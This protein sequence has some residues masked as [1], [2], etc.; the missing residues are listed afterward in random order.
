MVNQ[1]V[2]NVV[3]VGGGTAG[4]LAAAALSKFVGPNITITLVESDEI[5]VVGVGEATIPTIR[6]FHYLLG[7]DEKEFLSAVNGTFKLG[8][9]FSYWKNE[10]DSYIH[11]FGETGRGSWAAEFH[12]Y[13]RKGLILDA[14][15]AYGDYCLELQAAKAGKFA[16]TENPHMN[17]AYHMD[18]R[19]YAQ[20]LRSYSEKLGVKRIEGRIN[21]VQTCAVSGYI[22]SVQLQSGA[23]ISGDLFIDCSG[24]V[25]LLIEQT[26]KTGYEDWTHW[27]PCNRAVAVQTESVQ[28]ALP[29]TRAI[30]HDSG[31]QW[32]IPLQNRVG[33]GLVYSSEYLSDE[34]AQKQLLASVNGKTLMEPKLIKFVTGCRVKNWNKNCVAL[35]LSSG[36]VEPLE[37]TSIHLVTSALLRLVKLFPAQGITPVCVDEF[38]MQSRKEMEAVRDF[39]MLHYYV[40]NRSSDFWQRCR[41]MPVPDSLRHRVELF[42]RTGRIFIAADELFTLGSW[43]QVMI[44]QGLMP[45]EYHPMVDAVEEPEL[46]AFLRGYKS[47]VEKNVSMLPKHADFVRQFCGV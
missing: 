47:H 40:N 37:S 36:F 9:D 39:V 45:R 6:S 18:A 2:Q 38:N 21:A 41:T 8:I 28:E 20:F 27:L 32:Q 30:A 34:N 43:T 46:V 15:A 35:G 10:Q 22:Q 5:G 11:S 16:I 26:L 14:S 7:I 33:N 25:G 4:W 3:I 44:G 24:F 17:Y 23:F 29:Y 12:H 1:A 31:W 13:W 42:Q 19:L